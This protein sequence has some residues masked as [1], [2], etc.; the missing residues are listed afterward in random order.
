[1]EQ[2]REQ[3]WIEANRAARESFGRLAA[4][5]AAR[6]GDIALA[7]D[8]LSEAFVAALETWPETGVPANP[9]G[10]LLV[11]ARRRASDAWKRLKVRLA[12]MPDLLQAA[13]R[14][15]EHAGEF[16]FPDERLRLMFVCAH[17]AI[18]SEN[19][20][21]LML[22]TVLGMDAERIAHAFAMQPAAMGQRLVRTKRKIADAA[23][24]FEI[25]DEH[26]LPP[27]LEAV[28]EAIYGAYGTGWDELGAQDGRADLADE[29]LYLGSL[30]EKMLP[31]EPEPA[32]LM[33]L[34]LFCESRRGA[35]RD[36]TG[37]YVPFDEQDP[38][39]WNAQLLQ[40][41]ERRLHR[42]RGLGST[43]RFQ[44][45]AAIQSALSVR[46]YGKQREID[47]D[48]LLVLY[49]GLVEKWPTIGALVG[50]AAVVAKRAG[51]AAGLGALSAV[52]AVAAS[53]FQPYWAV[54]AEL[55]RQLGEAEAEQARQ[56][57]G[58]ACELT[59]DPSVKAWL[60][61]RRADIERS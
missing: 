23:V 38:Q 17:P 58:R 5:L 35:R 39:L 26:A 1:L 20:T 50:R 60:A 61:G 30:L 31:N 9:E 55:L 41:A 27:R 15:T 40:L 56:A 57:Y 44:L 53:G 36:S 11:T 29:A 45:E 21:P 34:M 28:M 4:L 8:V 24:P 14:E 3:A 37:G 48:S 49:S 54:K 52:S 47:W 6:T 42:A 7:E 25:P 2:Q 22:Q 19:H 32:G 46:A 33:A 43:G 59:R 13:E 12:A 18:D 16:R 10:W 51:A